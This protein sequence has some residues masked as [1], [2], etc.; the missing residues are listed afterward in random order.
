MK[1]LV[2]TIREV[3]IFLVGN[4]IFNLQNVYQIQ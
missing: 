2:V 1:D 4:E 3:Y